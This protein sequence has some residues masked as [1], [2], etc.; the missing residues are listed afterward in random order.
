MTV[1]H[2]PLSVILILTDLEK[3]RPSLNVDKCF[4]L[5]CIVCLFAYDSEFRLFVVALE[6]SSNKTSHKHFLSGHLDPT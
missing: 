5:F 4:L 1:L 3:L 6:T 2:N